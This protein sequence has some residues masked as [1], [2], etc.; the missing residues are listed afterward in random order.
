MSKDG[1]TLYYLAR[2]ERGMNL[3]TTNLRTRETKQLVALDAQGG[4]MTW[5]K[6]QKAIFLLANGAISKIDP[7]SGR[8]EAVP[9]RPH[10]E[11]RPAVIGDVR[12][13][14]G[15]ARVQGAPG[16]KVSG[17]APILRRARVRCPTC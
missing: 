10:V 6:D 13:R 11:P 1:E 9:L 3:W 5:D 2:F 15:G 4:S 17:I 16:G 12:L 8:R 14:L 7:A